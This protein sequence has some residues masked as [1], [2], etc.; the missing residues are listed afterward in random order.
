MLYCRN[1]NPDRRVARWN[2]L[3]PV[4]LIPPVE[5]FQLRVN[6]PDCVSFPLP[7]RAQCRRRQLIRRDCVSRFLTSAYY[8]DAGETARNV[9]RLSKL[10]KEKISC[11]SMH[12]LSGSD[13]WQSQ[14]GRL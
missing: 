6:D 12:H 11:V 7:A 10:G 2:E 13:G 8:S 3:A 4:P 5:F 9:Q 1:G 14:R